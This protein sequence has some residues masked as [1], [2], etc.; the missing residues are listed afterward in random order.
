MGLCWII[1]PFIAHF[2]DK[3]IDKFVWNIII[4]I[5]SNICLLM[6]LYAIYDI[7]TSFNKYDWKKS[8]LFSIILI[9]FAASY[10][11]LF[12][13]Q[14][15]FNALLGVIA[16][17]FCWIFIKRKG[18]L[19]RSEIKDKSLLFDEEKLKEIYKKL[20]DQ[21]LYMDET[22]YVIPKIYEIIQQV[23]KR[24]KQRRYCSFCS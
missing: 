1:P 20:Y 19:T 17:P 24:K 18:G 13:S 9:M 5:H 23:F 12:Y 6:I 8:L 15:V 14:N 16:I 22:D 10:Y 7:V 21:E 2:F 4:Q 3:N 11:L